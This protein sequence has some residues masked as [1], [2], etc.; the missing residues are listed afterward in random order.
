MCILGMIR[1]YNCLCVNKIVKQNSWRPYTNLAGRECALIH[2]STNKDSY[3][4]KRHSYKPAEIAE[5]RK[6]R[7]ELWDVV[8]S[9]RAGCCIALKLVHVVIITKYARIEC[10][11]P[12]STQHARLF[13]CHSFVTGPAA[14]LVSLWARRACY[15]GLSCWRANLCVGICVQLMKCWHLCFHISMWRCCLTRGGSKFPSN[16]V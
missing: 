14:E 12:P 4:W 11:H 13:K 6:T 9:W 1:S 5:A 10:Q 8:H 3:N 2:M 7:T 15:F 16:V